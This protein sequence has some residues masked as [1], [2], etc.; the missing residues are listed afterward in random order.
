MRAQWRIETIDES[1]MKLS[2]I[3]VDNF[4][5]IALKS[6]VNL[7]RPSFRLVCLAAAHFPCDFAMA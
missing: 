1:K 3:S 6:K 5:E 2:T 4:V 7:Q